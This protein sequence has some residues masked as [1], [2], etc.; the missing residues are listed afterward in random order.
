M[1]TLTEAPDLHLYNSLHVFKIIG[2]VTAGCDCRKNH[3]LK[4]AKIYSKE[5][6]IYI[7]IYSLFLTP[8]H[9]NEIITVNY[10]VLYKPRQL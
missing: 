9:P 2:A 8:T 4:S 1:R 10:Q 7:F 3:Q 6:H 5:S